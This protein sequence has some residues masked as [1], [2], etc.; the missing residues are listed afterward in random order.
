M[1][2]F[3]LFL[4]CAGALLVTGC[5]STSTST[6]DAPAASDK[7]AARFNVQLG[8][9]YLQRGNLQD[10][11]E[12]LER[13]VEQDPNFPSAHAALGLLYERV[14]EM[15]RAG[16]HL[17]RAAQLAPDDAAMLNNYGG[18]LCRRGERQAGI[19]YFNR[20]A[21]NAFYR[22]PEVALTNAGVC[23]RGIPDVASA[24]AYF[25]RALE[26][27][28]TYPEALLQMADLKLAAGESFN[29]RA[30]MQRY[31]AVAT[32]TPV[33]LDLARRIELSAGDRDAAQQYEH[34]LRQEFP[35]S[36]ESRRLDDE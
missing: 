19:E 23:A 18:F 3:G 11:R 1:R 32:A 5:V 21:G 12:K 4:V 34:R 27:N 17:R 14:G 20:A 26:V 33:S 28:R 24:E 16:S 7:E 8:I 29:A 2:K 31:E 25:R 9:S 10:A 35:E 6:S 36:A 13:A 30:F 22:T 15:D